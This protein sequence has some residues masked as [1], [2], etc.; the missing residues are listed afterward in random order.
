[1]IRPDVLV[2][3]GG[4]T[5]GE[6]WLRSLL[7]GLEA[8][9]GWDLREC[10]AFVGT[11]A[12]SIVAAVLAA[13]RRPEAA[14]GVAES[15]SA[16]RARGRP[17]E[18]H[19]SAPSGLIATALGA[20]RPWRAAP[21][22]PSPRR[23]RRSSP[24]GLEPAGAALARRR[25]APRAAAD[26]RDPAAAARAR[27]ARRRVRRAPARRRRRPAQRAPR[28]L[29][30]ARRSRCQRHR[31]GARLLRGAV[32]LPASLDRRAR[33]RRRR[34]VERRQPRRGA[35]AQRDQVLC[36]NPTASPRL[37][38]DRLRRRARVRERRCRDRGAAAA[39]A[40]RACADRRA[41]TAGRS[42]RSGRTCSTRA[43]AP[44][45]R[46]RA[47][48]RAA[49][50]A[51]LTL[52]RAHEPARPRAREQGLLGG[53]GGQLRRAGEA[54]LGR[55]GDLV[56][57][58]RRARVRGRR[59]A[60]RRRDRR[61]R[62]R[63]RH[64]LRLRLARAPRRAPG[65]RRHHREPARDR[66]R[67]A[68]RAR[69]RVPADPGHAEDVPLPGRCADLVVSEY[70]ASLWCEPEAWISEAARLLRP[71]G[72]L[73]FLTNSLLVALTA[74]THGPN[75]D[76]LVRPQREISRLRFEDDEGVE[77]HLAH[78]DW[79]ALLIAPRLRG[80]RPARA[81]RAGRRRAY[82]ATTGCRSSGRSA[83]RSRRSGPRGCGRQRRRSS[84]SSADVKAK[85]GRSPPSI[86]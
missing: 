27:H 10:D 43:G 33:V 67:D 76:R 49:R 1:M 23:S 9:T 11:S 52:P 55:G 21:R 73:V 26:A 13:G 75:G 17:L 4:G 38:A 39:A 64:R 69:A 6:A 42:T 84:A 70:G 80:H 63:L 57:H 66:A 16:R 2:L 81:L 47:T 35:G 48:A 79:I 82:R 46:L 37:A 44:P 78:G 28:R 29:R 41:R 62:A 30:L 5:L 24:R 22:S 71:G 53:R 86:A 60:G 45:S 68:G 54:Q 65:R 56:G 74:P 8:E 32:G 85:P 12:G 77:F 51:P 3:G 59:A 14:R 83:G 72:R 15:W 40:R 50:S 25:A 34:R 36:L 58:L 20:D 31:G 7:A 18:G 19:R 61:R